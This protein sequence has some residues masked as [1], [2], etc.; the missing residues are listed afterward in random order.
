[1]LLDDQPSLLLH[2][3]DQLNGQKDLQHPAG[4]TQ[5]Q[6]WAEQQLTV[7]TLPDKTAETMRNV[8]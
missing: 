1:M 3:G 7:G 2:C 4:S 8:I 6:Q 5:E